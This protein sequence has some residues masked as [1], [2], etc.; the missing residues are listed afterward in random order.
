[1]SV[2]DRGRAAEIAEIQKQI[3]GGAAEPER[4]PY[5]GAGRAFMGKIGQPLQDTS[6]MTRR[7]IA[8]QKTHGEF[9][10]PI[11]EAAEQA[12]LAPL[13]KAIA[14][15]NQRVLRGHQALT[16]L[17]CSKR[18]LDELWVEQGHPDGC[19]LLAQFRRGQADASSVSATTFFNGPFKGFLNSD[20]FKK[21]RGS[22]VQTRVLEIILD[23]MQIQLID[24]LDARNWQ[25]VLLLM[26][27][28]TFVLPDPTFQ[29]AAPAQR[30]AAERIV[31]EVGGRKLIGK[32]AID[33]MSSVEFAHR[34]KE[35]PEFQSLVEE[36]ETG[37]PLSTSRKTNE[38]KP[39]PYA[40]NTVIVLRDFEGKSLTRRMIDELPSDKYRKAL[41]LIGEP[42]KTFEAVLDTDGFILAHLEARR[43][44][45]AR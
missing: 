11:D 36:V 27:S 24:E 5:S 45:W 2:R 26:E 29:P 18:N 39:D 31:Y 21:Y 40:Y 20:A 7:Q 35:E 9:A 23:W 4:I 25:K 16:D 43:Q 34:L 32:Q 13:L 37:K 10:R 44:Q 33:A 3:D 14:E 22:S 30:M 8:E 1:M 41:K 42:I 15:D 12:R 28:A 6:G 38:N 17:I 19:P